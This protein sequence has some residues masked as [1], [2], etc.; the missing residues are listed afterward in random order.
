MLTE[1]R[2][3]TA[4][5]L[6]WIAI[7]A[8]VIDH[9]AWKLTLDP[10]PFFLMHMVGRFTM[11]IMCFLLA[12]GFH[13]TSSRKRYALRLL[14]FA[15]VAQVPFTYFMY[16]QPVR[17][18]IGTETL[19]ALFCLLLGFCALWAVKS[20]RHPGVKITLVSLCLIGSLICDWMVFGV[21]WILVFGVSRGDFKRQTIGFAIAAVPL[22]AMAVGPA[23]EGD[24]QQLM[25]AGVF[26]TLPLLW[27]YNGKKSGPSTPAWVTNKWIFYV[28]YPAHLAL[29]GVLH[30]G[31]GWLR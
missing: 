8:M 23:L 26:L 29:L 9:V 6:K 5:S 4:N 13:H 27:R 19:N 17:L 20:N 28:F 2:W 31:L 1:R 21:L 30:Y 16:G 22:L 7:A 10:A 25:Q 18:W 3:F 15:V 12:E 14:V 24:F 11:P